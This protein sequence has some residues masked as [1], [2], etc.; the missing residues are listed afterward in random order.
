MVGLCLLVALMHGCAAQ[1]AGPE[2]AASTSS[3]FCTSMTLTSNAP[4]NTAPAGTKVTFTATATCPSGGSSFEFL[5]VPPG[6]A[7]IDLQPYSSS[8]SFTWDTTGLSGIYQIEAWENPA[9]TSPNSPPETSAVLTFTVPWTAC[10]SGTLSATPSGTQAAGT[11]ITVTAGSSTCPNPRYQFLELAP[12]GSWQIVQ[13]YGPSNTYAWNTTGDANG[14]YQF[15]VWIKDAGA[16]GA[17]SDTSAVT[18]ATLTPASSVCTDVSL[19]PN[20]GSPQYLGATVTLT[21]GSSA[22]VGTPQYAFYEHAPGGSWELVQPYSSSDTF[23]FTG[24]EE[25]TYDFEVDVK[26]SGSTADYESYSALSYDFIACSSASV[27]SSLPQ[28]Q[29]VDTPVTFTASASGCT[30]SP[31]YAFYELA[32]DG[33][34]WAL[35]QPYSSSN[36]FS[37]RS[38]AAGTYQ[39]QVWVRDSGSTQP[40]ETFAMFS[41]TLTPVGSACTT[42]TLSASPA[43]PQAAGTPVTLTAGASSCGDPQYA[44]YELAPGGS[45]TLVQPYSSSPTFNF[46]SSTAGTYSFQVWARSAVSSAASETVGSLTYVLQ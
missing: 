32:P 36:T 8:N 41:Y 43:G 7:W 29:V 26:G 33:S 6:G 20:I 38:P 17:S 46:T 24:T 11:P 25:G 19:T 39:F 1:P 12:N 16:A 15:E 40:Y 35:V 5:E 37:F 9:P 30:G 23:S 10:T 4:Q 3:A 45:W 42:A 27:S 31:Q 21:A 22:C 44:F 18:S 14:T 28:P 2:N 13:P 34:P